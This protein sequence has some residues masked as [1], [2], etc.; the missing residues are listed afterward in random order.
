[1]QTMKQAVTYARAA[2]TVKGQVCYGWQLLEGD[3]GALEMERSTHDTSV[4][5][6]LY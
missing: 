5:T 2:A 3:I 6:S 4:A 1:M